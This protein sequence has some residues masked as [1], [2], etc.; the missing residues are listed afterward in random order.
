MRFS[1]THSEYQG[2]SYI[3]GK[4]TI[5]FLDPPEKMHVTFVG[6]SWKIQ[7]IF[8]IQYSRNIIWDYS[9]EFLRE[10]FSNI[11]RIDVPGIFHEYIFARW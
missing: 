10:F 6:Y 1:K 9:P 8:Y 5:A 2:Q 3:L 7:G 11:P 4:T